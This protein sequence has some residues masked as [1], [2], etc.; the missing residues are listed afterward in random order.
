M[1]SRM[2]KKTKAILQFA[3]TAL[4]GT[5]F[6]GCYPPPPEYAETELIMQRRASLK[7]NLLLM[8]PE[9]IR[10]ETAAH[11]EAQWIADTAYKAAAAIARQYD[12]NFPG[13]A[14]NYL[15]NSRLQNRGLCWQYQHDLYRELRRKKLTYY[16]LGC[17]VRDQ[18]KR[19]E[20][21]C[22]FVYPKHSGWPT[23]WVLD[24]WPWNGRLQVFNARSLRPDRWQERD[25]AA[26]VLNDTYPEG[27]DMPMEHWMHVRADRRW[28]EFAIFG[29][30]GHYQD[31][32]WPGTWFSAQYGDML[33]NITEG[34]KEHPNTA[35]RY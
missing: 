27:H 31:S 5:S 14:G 20:H 13:W 9:N 2:N 1:R 10:K 3:A 18:G 26:D 33:H 17:C 24:G 28:Y 21:N 4:I 22:V 15:V 16:S 19:S 11:Q 25:Y 29:M 30:P 12:S 8:L 6:S 23:A 32:W 7:E 35:F 34:N